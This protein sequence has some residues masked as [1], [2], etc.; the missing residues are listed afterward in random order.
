[1]IWIGQPSILTAIFGLVDATPLPNSGISIRSCIQFLKKCPLTVS[2]RPQVDRKYLHSFSSCDVKTDQN[3]FWQ[4]QTVGNTKTYSNLCILLKIA[5]IEKNRSDIAQFKIL[6]NNRGISSALKISSS[7]PE[8][9]FFVPLSC[10]DPNIATT[11]PCLLQSRSSFACCIHSQDPTRKEG[12][13]VFVNEDAR[14]NL[15]YVVSFQSHASALEY[16][17]SDLSLCNG[18]M[19]SIFS[20]S[21]SHVLRL[22]LDHSQTRLYQKNQLSE[23]GIQ[24]I[25]NVGSRFDLSCLERT[26]EPSTAS[27][28]LV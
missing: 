23:K 17:A 20:M 11:R 10:D 8:I 5:S 21:S 6:H 27:Y 9:H 7:S 14:G 26:G 1:M 18:P 4:L 22:V 28:P 15:K 19:A 16:S 12:R 3:Q 2:R 13:I 25:L 24:D